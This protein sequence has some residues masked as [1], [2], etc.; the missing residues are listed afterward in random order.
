LAE[1]EGKNVAEAVLAPE[2]EAMGR[3]SLDQA[4]VP[5]LRTESLKVSI[6]LTQSRRHGQN[7]FFTLRPAVL[8]RS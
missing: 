3:I 5:A 7:R 4:I 2:G 1:D 6:S 8:C